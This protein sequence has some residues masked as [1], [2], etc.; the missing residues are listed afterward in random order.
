MRR[1]VIV[2]KSFGVFN[3]QHCRMKRRETTY[4]TIGTRRHFVDYQT[5]ADGL[6]KKH[7]V[8]IVNGS[9][10][11]ESNI[12]LN[13]STRTPI[14]AI[15]GFFCTGDIHGA[16]SELSNNNLPWRNKSRPRAGQLLADCYKYIFESFPTPFHFVQYVRKNLLAIRFCQKDQSRELF[17]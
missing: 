16:I 14:L 6:I 15:F 7:R 17:W 1:N 2:S 8:K 10:D 3:S 4:P 13:H 12:P 5:P 9:G 11:H